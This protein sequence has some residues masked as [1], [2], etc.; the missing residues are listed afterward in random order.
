[1]NK[2]LVCSVAA[3]ATSHALGAWPQA[4]NPIKESEVP[5]RKNVAPLP[6]RGTYK[7]PRTSWGDP[8]IAGA[9]NN[10]DETGIPFERPAEFADRTLESF[11]LEELAS[12]QEQRQ[13]QT[14]ERN[15]TLSEFP[16]ATSPMHWF[17]NY[18][19][20]NSRP[21]LV[22][23]PPDGK[24]PAQ[25]EEA[26][27]ARSRCARRASRPRTCRLLHRSQPLRPLHYARRAGLDDAGDLR[28]LVSH[29]SKPRRRDD[30]VRD[31]P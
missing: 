11:A 4:S 30:H 6:P 20:A 2:R 17:E 16:G 12:I 24:V 28:Q 22:S 15:P 25:T 1:M 3:F 26:R 10:S 8:A 23:D 7:A 29:R 5:Q 13:R 21:W 31:D 19:A 27:S 14:I 18:F 9:Y